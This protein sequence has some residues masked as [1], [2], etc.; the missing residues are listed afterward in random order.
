MPH[1]RS[2]A[3]ANAAADAICALCDSGTIRIYAGDQPG[4]PDD[5]PTGA[6]LAA[7]AFSATAFLPAVNGTALANEIADAIA[8]ASGDASWYRLCAADGSAVTDDEC[9]VAGSGKALEL[10]ILSIAAGD[11]V[12]VPNFSH[13]EPRHE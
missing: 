11:R 2:V 13:T 5:A 9:G 1:R 6:L 3:A 10:R 7:P 4:T 8:V 12:I